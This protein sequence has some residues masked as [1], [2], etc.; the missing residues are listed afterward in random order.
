MAANSQSLLMRQASQRTVFNIDDLHTA[1]E[2]WKVISAEIEK[3]FVTFSQ[4]SP[5]ISQFVN[6]VNKSTFAEYLDEPFDDFFD[7]QVVIGDLIG[8]NDMSEL[9]ELPSEPLIQ[10]LE[11]LKA[12][13]TTDFIAEIADAFPISEKRIKKLP[14][15]AQRSFAAIALLV[16]DNALNNQFISWVGNAM[17]TEDWHGKTSGE[18]QTIRLCGIFERSGKKLIH[19]HVKYWVIINAVNTLSMWPLKNSKQMTSFTVG[20]I[21]TSRSGKTLKIWKQDGTLGVKLSCREKLVKEAWLQRQP[22]VVSSFTFYGPG[23]PGDV[24]KAF[25]F[26]LLQP[27]TYVLRAMLSNDVLKLSS[28]TEAMSDLFTVFS[29]AQNVH[30]LFMTTCAVE[31]SKHDVTEENLLRSTSHL[32]CLFKVLYN[33]FGREY[34]REVLL[35]IIQR[36]RDHSVFLHGGTNIDQGEAVS[37]IYWVLEKIFASADLL[38][39][40]FQHM[41][42]VLKCTASTTFRKKKT[43]FNAVSSFIYIRFISAV[44]A[45]PQSFDKN[46]EMT[47][48]HQSKVVPFAELLQAPLGLQRLYDRFEY[49]AFLENRIMDRYDEIYDFVMNSSIMENL[50]AYPVPPQEQCRRALHRLMQKLSEVRENFIS[51]YTEIYDNDTDK[52][53]ASFA[54]ANLISSMFTK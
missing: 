38:P 42:A 5:F 37:Q 35:P 6:D 43:V 12:I 34:A 8:T 48:D 40:P 24:A 16:Q 36:V 53:A 19:R 46:F 25:M 47:P 22:L 50:P 3:P 33:R 20:R 10:L 31:F 21:G 51:R 52:S 1:D 23:I 41:S 11:A 45:D 15:E 14:I 27:D 29:Y 39:P 26:A 4:L 32:T 18:S 2:K 28:A 7:F 54:M 49:A 44:I 9:C 30:R 13:V 17:I